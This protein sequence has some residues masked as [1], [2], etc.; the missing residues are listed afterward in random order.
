MNETKW[1]KNLESRIQKDLIK[2]STKSQEVRLESASRLTYALEISDYDENDQPTTIPT[3]YQT[4]LLIYDLY[5]K[6]K[7]IP[8]VVIDCKIKRV[9]T[10]DA[11][12][13]S[14]K[15]ATHKN[16]HPYL[17]YGI[18]IGYLGTEVPIRLIRHGAHFDFM[19]VWDDFEPTGN[20]WSKFLKI[21][22]K[23][24][25]TSRKLQDIFSRKRKGKKTYS[26]IHRQT[27]FID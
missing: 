21:L 1:C 23:E 22:K 24:I 13:Y 25:E 7:W 4:D 17:R 12:V 26:I 2:I 20:E 27:H 10:H 8:R 3:E 18:L 6:S 16:V 19:M 9:T 15:A 14:S 11:L 5:E